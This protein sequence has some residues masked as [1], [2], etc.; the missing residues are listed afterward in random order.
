MTQ[1]Y[2]KEELVNWYNEHRNSANRIINDL[3]RQTYE[4]VMHVYAYTAKLVGL[5]HIV[6]QQDFPTVFS[7]N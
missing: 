2:N 6:S 3:T 7:N 1:V 5:D 4:G